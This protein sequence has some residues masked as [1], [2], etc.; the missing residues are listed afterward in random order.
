MKLCP[1]LFLLHS[2]FTKQGNALYPVVNVRTNRELK[3]VIHSVIQYTKVHIL[4]NKLEPLK[5]P[6]I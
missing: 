3:F 2:L 4:T 6:F 5:F 1:V